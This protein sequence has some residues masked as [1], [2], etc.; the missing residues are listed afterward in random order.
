LKRVLL[1]RA[2]GDFAIALQS[3]LDSPLSAD[4]E[5]IASVHHRPLFDAIAAVRKLDL[6]IRFID[7]GIQKSQLR[8]FTNRHLLHPATF[9]ELTAVKQFLKRESLPA[10]DYFVEQEHR[11]WLL[12]MAVIRPFRAIAGPAPVYSQ[13]H[14]FFNTASAPMALPSEGQQKY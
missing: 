10:S 2:Y 14:Q 7:W 9:K 11:K 4:L 5:L 1:L 6:P 3:A 12:E 13:F 8:A